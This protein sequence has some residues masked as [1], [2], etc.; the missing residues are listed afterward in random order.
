MGAQVR[1]LTSPLL[2]SSLLIAWESSRGWTK[3]LWDLEEALTPGSWLW[4]SSA[5][6][7]AVTWE[8]NQQTEDLCLSSTLYIC[9]SNW[10]QEINEIT[11]KKCKAM[12]MLICPSV[13]Y[14]VSQNYKLHKLL[15]LFSRP[16][17]KF[18]IWDFYGFEHKQD[19]GIFSLCVFSNE[20]QQRIR[21]L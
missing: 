4:I 7:V 18:Y 15:H 19:P 13:R 10:K 12:I 17:L 8:V 2:S 20:T 21:S 11:F 5:L 16:F 6:A 1:V 3:T 9:L 14:T